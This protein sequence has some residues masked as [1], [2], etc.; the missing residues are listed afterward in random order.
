MEASQ[1]RD[2]AALERLLGFLAPLAVRLLHLREAVRL[3]PTRPAADL[4]GADPVA[5]VA[6]RTGAAGAGMT[7]D[8]FWRLVA[9]LG[10]HQG[11][12]RDGPPGWQTLWHGW[13]YLQTLVEGVHLAPHLPPP[14]C[15]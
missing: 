13:L 9:R 15:G 11:R 3:T 1:L 14:R 6:A 10:G 2:E 7:A 4:V 5:V 12:T 8:A